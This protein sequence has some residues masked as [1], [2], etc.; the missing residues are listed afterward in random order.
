MSVLCEHV[1]INIVCI[2][3]LSLTHYSVAEIDDV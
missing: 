1:K 2:V 3:Q